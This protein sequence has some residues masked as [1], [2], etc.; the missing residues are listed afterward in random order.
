VLLLLLCLMRGAVPISS[1]YG[2]KLQ[3]HLATKV[4]TLLAYTSKQKGQQR[5]P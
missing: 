4:S 2:F 1:K 3:D 5:E